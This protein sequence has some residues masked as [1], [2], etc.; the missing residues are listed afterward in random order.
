[1]MVRYMKKIMFAIV[2]V[3]IIAASGCP[4]GSA[5]YDVNATEP[6][7]LEK[8]GA[9]PH[10]LCAERGLDDKII[11]LETKYCGA[12]KEAV[13]LL[14]ELEQELGVDILFFDISVNEDREKVEEFGIIVRYT[15]T[16]VIGCDVH[17]GSYPKEKYESLIKKH[18]NEMTS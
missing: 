18:L 10:D 11:V 12:C 16:V 7:M 2:L 1:M 5:D 3:M 6:I 4:N 17:I 13:P 15:P 8:E 14:K 9:I